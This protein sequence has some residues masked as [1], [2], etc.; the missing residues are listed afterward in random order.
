[1]ATGTFHRRDVRRRPGG[2]RLSEPTAAWADY[3]NDGDLDLFIGNETGA[4]PMRVSCYANDGDTF[5]DVAAAAGVQNLQ[6]AQSVGV[7]D[8][9]GDT[10]P[11]LYVSNLGADDRL[12]RNNADGSSPTS[13]PRSGQRAEGQIRRMVLGFRQ[14]GVL[15]I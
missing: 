4:S 14:D 11:D 3:D 7:G 9:D 2:K 15:D 1:M 10:W 5:T 8:Y 13:P 12:Y 6:F